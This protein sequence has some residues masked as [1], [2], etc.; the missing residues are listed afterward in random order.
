M[1]DLVEAWNADPTLTVNAL[2]KRAGCTWWEA[3]KALE[4]A[5]VDWRERSPN[6]ARTERDAEVVAALDTGRSLADVG[7][8]FGLTRQRVHQIQ[9]R[10][11]NMKYI[12]HLRSTQ[13][14]QDKAAQRKNSAGGYSFAVSA[15]TRLQRF[16]VL[17]AEGS[18]YYATERALV[19]ENAAA[20]REMLQTTEG[21][22]KAVELVTEVSEAGRAPKND[23]AIF[24][25]AMAC[26]EGTEQT[27]QAAYRAVP[28]VCRTGTHLFQWA[29]T[30]RALGSTLGTGG[31][32]RAVR[33]WYCDRTAD[34]LA[35]QVTKYRQR[36]GWTHRDVMLLGHVHPG[37]E[38]TPH[39]EVLR[40]AA[41]DGKK[42]AARPEVTVEAL[43]GFEALQRAENPHEAAKLIEAYRAPREWVPSRLLASPRVWEALLQHMPMTAMV[44]NL[45]KMSQVGLLVPL[46]AASKT[47]A[48]KLG[49]AELV[50][51]SRMHPLQVLSA[52]QVYRSGRGVRGSLSW[53]PIGAVVDALDGA[54]YTAFG[55]V[56]PSGK[57]ML[58]ALDVSGSM[59]WGTIAGV[60][61]VTPAVGAAAMA[62]VTARTE[63]EYHIMAF[64]DVLKDLN[65]CSAD[66]LGQVMEKTRRMS[67]GRTDCALPMVWA[68]QNNVNVDC[69]SVY[70]DSETYAGRVHPHIALKEYRASSGIPAR[71]ITVGMESNGFTLA[72]PDDTNMLDV[73]GFDTA[74][75]K[76]ISVFA[77]GLL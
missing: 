16:L 8:E 22:L 32:R 38:A 54:F 7:A 45:G 23:A 17:G 33:R 25:L 59:S 11:T 35:Y 62:M 42:G 18:T 64:S 2:A 68:K 77:A 51:R 27:R 47:V 53:D 72:D 12:D 13:R 44:R 56:Q 4:A 36:E 10:G 65:I 20:L 34:D 60:P 37:T 31:A 61:G 15:Q 70:T 30:M 46:S 52:L 76:L 63:P 57:R 50:I 26:R 3:R 58:L 40:W 14:E 1:H 69:F 9:K 43:Q 73:V 6:K 19:R 55:N 49:R 71:S 39:A 74:T 48:D 21:G 66:S 67:M 75:P 5:G 24:A 28:R 41:A 29:G